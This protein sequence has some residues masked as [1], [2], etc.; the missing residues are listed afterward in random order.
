MNTIEFVQR[1][2]HHAQ[3]LERFEI[4]EIREN[5]RAGINFEELG[6]RYQISATHAARVAREQCWRFV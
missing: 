4:L 3:K 6:R 5:N 1:H 2:R